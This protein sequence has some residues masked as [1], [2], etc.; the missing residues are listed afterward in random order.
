MQNMQKKYVKPFAICR[1]VTSPDFASWYLS[2][3]CTPHFA[4]VT[5]QHDPAVPASWIAGRGVLV[6]CSATLQAWVY[7]GWPDSCDS[8][9]VTS[10]VGPE[11]SESDSEPASD[12]EEL[13]IRM[14][15][16]TCQ[17]KHLALHLY[18]KFLYD[19][20]IEKRSR[21]RLG[22]RN[23]VANWLSFHAGK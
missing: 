14:P 19:R 5:R 16:C 3:V 23:T 15:E 8:D 4:D 12:S 1:I 20:Q 21:S 9:S 17:T 13:S 11:E 18:T 2:Y 6:S 22:M 7:S 10:T